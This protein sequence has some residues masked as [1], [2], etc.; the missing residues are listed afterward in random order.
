MYG[1]VRIWYSKIV[2]CRIIIE[3]LQMIKNLFFD[4][5][6]TL[7]DPKEGI[8][9]SVAYALESFYNLEKVDALNAKTIGDCAFTSCTSL[10]N[11]VLSESLTELNHSVFSKCSATLFKKKFK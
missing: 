5:D 11:L 2:Y 6:G 8:T 9:K 3:G 1:I 10:T 7:T 4:L